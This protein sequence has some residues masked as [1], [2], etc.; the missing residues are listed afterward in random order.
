MAKTGSDVTLEAIGNLLDLKLGEFRLEINDRFR[1]VNIRLDNFAEQTDGR[2]RGVEDRL[3]A[4]GDRMR[5][6]ERGMAG[7][8]NVIYQKIDNLKGEMN[9]R[10]EDADERVEEVLGKIQEFIGVTDKS[11]DKKIK[12]LKNDLEPRIEKLEHGFKFNQ[13]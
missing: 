7:L 9:D 1:E 2:F 11:E 6:L 5:K 13:I 10:F 12:D 3:D 8:R 4:Q